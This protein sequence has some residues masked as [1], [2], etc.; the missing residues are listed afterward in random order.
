MFKTATEAATT[1]GNIAEKTASEFYQLI[2]QTT[3]R[4]GRT[5]EAIA[6]NPLFRF[7]DKIPGIGWGVG[8]LKTAIG[9]VNV[10]E[11]QA[12]V[13]K[14]KSQ[15]PGENESQIAHRLIVEKSLEAGRLG[16]LANFIPPIAAAM[17]GIE[18]V[19]IAKLQAEMVYEIA[20]AYG[21]DIKEPA[22]RG[23]VLAI[24]G[25]SFGG[26][27]LKAG[28]NFIEIIPGVGAVVGASTNA[29]MLYVIGQTS[30]RFYEGKNHF[31]SKRRWQQEREKDWQTALAQCEIMDR[32]LVHMVRTSYPERSWSKILSVLKRVSPSSTKT[33][34]SE[35]EN[36]EPLDVLLNQLSPDF[37]PLV[38]QRCNEIA[39]LDG[40][41]TFEEQKILDAIAQKFNLELP[42]KEKAL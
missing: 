1:V 8:W 30:C 42:N 20:A 41:I 39:R 23:E 18:L 38:W 11:T 22:R 15:Y 35:L 25:L 14:F 6:Q 3:D 31:L 7:A 16:F 12:K 32:I 9:E 5:L 10:V 36:P 27:F 26:N 4:T 17:L 33:V 28:L 37:A 13:N 24:Y 2:E 29:A 21:L 19:A 40:M 34:A